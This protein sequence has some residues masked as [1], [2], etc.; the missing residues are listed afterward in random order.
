[1]SST[2]FAGLD[3]RP[4]IWVFFE[5]GVVVGFVSLAAVKLEETLDAVIFAA[6]ESTFDS[7]GALVPCD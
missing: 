2:K 3:V 5:D 4:F 7:V 1:M 6:V